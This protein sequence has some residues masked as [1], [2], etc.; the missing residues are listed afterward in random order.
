MI[1][2]HEKYN[3]GDKHEFKS[4]KELLEHLMKKVNIK[5]EQIGVNMENFES[6]KKKIL[7][8]KKTYSH[9]FTISL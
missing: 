9:S 7:N 1:C 8:E 4:E 6:S 5:P 3:L 2:W